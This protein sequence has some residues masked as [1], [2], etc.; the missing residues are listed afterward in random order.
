[1]ARDS[2]KILVIPRHTAID[3]FTMGGLA[4]DAGL[5]SEQFRELL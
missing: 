1:M 4:K 2:A 3:E 5:T